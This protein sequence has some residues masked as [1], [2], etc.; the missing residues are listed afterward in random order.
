MKKINYYLSFLAVF[1]LLLTSCSKEDDVNLE[2]DPAKATL[3]FGTFLN[4][5]TANKAA[6][7][8]AFENIPECSDDAPVYVE[9]VLSQNGSPVVGTIGDPVRVTVNPNPDDYDEDGVEEYFTNESA[10]LELDPGIYSL[11]YFT[12]LN[13]DEDII[14][15]APYDD[16][17]PE[18]FGDFVDTALP[19]DIDLTA[20][21][22]K[23]VDVEVLCFDDRM[24]N[25]YGY[26]FFDLETNQAVEYCFFANFCDN[27][28]NH[29]PAHYSINVW[30]GTDDT[31]RLLYSD[32]MN[33]VQSEGDSPSAAPLCF[34]LPD[35]PEHADDEDYIYY[36]VTLLD[37]EAVYGDVEESV[38]SGT[39]SRNDIA[40]NFDGDDQVDY[41]HLRFGCDDSNGGDNNNEDENGDEDDSS[42]DGDADNSDEDNGD[43]DD[44]DDDNSNDNDED[45]G[46]DNENGDD[47]GSVN[48]GCDTAFMFGEYELNEDFEGIEAERWGW[49]NFVKG[50]GTYTYDLWT[51]AGQNNTSAGTL[52]GEVT[53]IVDGDDVQVTIDLA[54]G[55]SLAET[56][57]YLDGDEPAV[58]GPGQYGNTNEGMEENSIVY[59][60]EVKDINED[61]SFWIVVH[62]E[63]C[64]N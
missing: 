17:T 31:G 48:K 29:Y 4:D 44:G 42:D 43:E 36:E 49:A 6:F 28:G 12:V 64:G 26:L 63:V 11:E 19:F 58:N 56:H 33:A 3:S 18:S 27:N 46:D 57:I 52:V 30:I 25:E 50:D 8:Q 10:D 39:L 13:A 47:Y 15:V 45:N 23:Y 59:N 9:V 54:E 61:G 40:A 7:K 20:G 5:M 2:N 22:K 32:K 38:I 51:G 24:V 53:Y 55:N 16:G 60:L 21:G 37:W 34:V 62:A 41:E 35:F 14:W 1:A